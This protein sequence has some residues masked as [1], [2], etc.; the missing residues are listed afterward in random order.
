MAEEVNFALYPGQAVQGI[1]DYS[2][3]EGIDFYYHA[4]SKISN[5]LFDATPEGLFGFIKDME[6][7]A[8]EFGWTT[9]Y[10]GIFWIPSNYG[11]IKIE[12]L[13]RWEQSYLN[14]KVREAQDSVQ[15]FHALRN[16]LSKRALNKLNIYEDQ[17]VIDGVPSG[18]LFWKVI[19]TVAAMKGIASS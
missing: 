19:V 18:P 7:R 8:H 5:E 13:R 16:S 9:E 10:S 1:I 2:T 12:D 6:H 15:A 14:E 4:T 17:Y 3:S 11:E